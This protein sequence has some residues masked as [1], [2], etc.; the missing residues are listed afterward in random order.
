MI[1]RKQKKCEAV[2]HLD[3]ASITPTGALKGAR[4][5]QK[6]QRHG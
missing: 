2:F 5:V 1:E 3:R 6:D 4:K